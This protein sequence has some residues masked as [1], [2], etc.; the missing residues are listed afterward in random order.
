SSPS[1]GDRA[2]TSAQQVGTGPHFVGLPHRPA[3]AGRRPN[4]TDGSDFA[5]AEA[6]A[7]AAACPEAELRGATA[8][9]RRASSEWPLPR[10]VGGWRRLA[11]TCSCAAALRRAALRA[12]PARPATTC[13]CP[14][15]AAPAG[16]SATARG[17]ACDCPAGA[18]GPRCELVDRRRAAERPTASCGC[19]GALPTRRLVPGAAAAAAR[20]PAISWPLCDRD[21]D[22]CRRPSRTGRRGLCDGGSRQRAESIG[23]HR[24]RPASGC[25]ANPGAAIDGGA[26]GLSEQPLLLGCASTELAAVLAV[27]SSLPAARAGRLL[28]V[29]CYGKRRRG[30]RRRVTMATGA[31]AKQHS[32]ASMRRRRRLPGRPW[33]GGDGADADD[34]APMI[35]RQLRR[36]GASLTYA[37]SR[38]PLPPPLTLLSTPTAAARAAALPGP[39]QAAQAGAASHRRCSAS[40]APCGVGGL[41]ARGSAASWWMIR[42]AAALIEDQFIISQ[43]GDQANHWDTSDWRGAAATLGGLGRVQGP[44][45]NPPDLIM[46][47]GP[48]SVSYFGGAGCRKRR[49]RRHR[50]LRTRRRRHRRRLGASAGRHRLRR[51]WQRLRRA[52]CSGSAARRPRRRET[53]LRVNETSSAEACRRRARPDVTGAFFKNANGRTCP[54]RIRRL[55]RQ[56]KSCRRPSR[57]VRMM[58][59]AAV[60]NLQAIPEPAG[61]P[62][63]PESS[64]HERKAQRQ[65]DRH[66]QLGISFG[67]HLAEQ[68]RLSAAGW[69][70]SCRTASRNM[71]LQ[72]LQAGRSSF[73]A[74]NS[75]SCRRLGLPEQPPTHWLPQHSSLPESGSPVANGRTAAAQCSRE[76]AGS[77]WARPPD[78]HSPPSRGLR[79]AAGGVEVAPPGFCRELMPDGGRLMRSKLARLI[80]SR[81]LISSMGSVLI[82]PDEAVQRRFGDRIDAEVLDDEVAEHVLAAGH[83]ARQLGVQP[84]DVSVRG[85]AAMADP[86]GFAHAVLRHQRGQQRGEQGARQCSACQLEWQFSFQ[87]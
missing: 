17:F 41:G 45:Q 25:P 8:R 63:L 80:T 38:R 6:A 70:I 34:G 3:V 59:E 7:S 4:P 78:Q 71:Q 20:A 43:L 2:S 68:W 72:L 9:R 5:E 42:G 79:V 33:R 61:W 62:G 31:L 35:K 57:S 10:E 48:F 74:R 46:D 54:T 40:R 22:E 69:E 14:E 65:T 27:V 85:V 52:R 36:P 12:E 18:A 32:P 51:R 77:H 56:R 86:N 84:A 81:P 47:G 37:A 87:T 11:S 49:Q 24:N 82:L 1:S 21:V 29:S 83:G 76:S 66:W 58:K 30:R 26:L 50:R 44:R 60:E 75:R 64:L 55:R 16:T 23:F 19:R 73:K 39:A 67:G 28:L 15:R 13:L 53:E